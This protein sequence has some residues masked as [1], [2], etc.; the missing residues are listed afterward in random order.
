MQ[1]TKF[2][3]GVE[4]LGCYNTTTPARDLVPRSRT[5]WGR[6]GGEKRE[7]TLNTTNKE[8]CSMPPTNFCQDKYPQRDGDV[9]ERKHREIKRKNDHV[10]QRSREA[11][12]L[13]A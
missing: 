12:S 8:L 7:T 4:F 11:F 13:K 9:E 2:L 6:G 10:K 1:Q 5:I 3:T